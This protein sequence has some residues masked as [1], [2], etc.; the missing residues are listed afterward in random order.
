[1]EQLLL[2]HQ[3]ERGMA[4]LLIYTMMP[5]YVPVEIAPE[6]PVAPQLH[7]VLKEQGMI[8]CQW[9][10]LAQRVS[11]QKIRHQVNTNII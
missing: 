2:R 8:A 4:A 11:L 5:F 10:N 6:E 7:C 1:M 3:V 9:C